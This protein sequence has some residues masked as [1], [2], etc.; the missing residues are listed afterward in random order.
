DFVERDPVLII[1]AIRAVHDKAPDPAHAQ[2]VV[3]RARR[4]AVRAP[5]LRQM[6]G[7]GPGGPDQIAR[8]VEYAHDHHCAR[9]LRKVK[10]ACCGHLSSPCAWLAVPRIAAPRLAGPADKPQAVEAF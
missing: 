1:A 7:I 10:A 4:E 3:T 2:V 9:V 6:L 5:P 8:R